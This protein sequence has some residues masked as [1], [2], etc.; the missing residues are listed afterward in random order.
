M[1]HG[2]GHSALHESGAGEAEQRWCGHPRGCVCAGG[3]LYELLTGTTPIPADEGNEPPLS[4]LLDQVRRH[5]TEKPS[6]R[7]MRLPKPPGSNRTGLDNASGIAEEP[8]V[9][10]PDGAESGR[11]CA[12]LPAQ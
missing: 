9:A 3:L 6:L 1:R 7:V 5:E 2:T 8:R 12:A 4:E 11:G 10:L